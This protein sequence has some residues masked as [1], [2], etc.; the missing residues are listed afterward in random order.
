M[1]QYSINMFKIQVCQN[2]QNMHILH[3]FA[4]SYL[5]DKFENSSIKTDYPISARGHKMTF[6]YFLTT[7][8][9]YGAIISICPVHCICHSHSPNDGIL[10]NNCCNIPFQTKHIS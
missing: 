6:L 8:T 5:R 3:I 2:M 10:K 1:T 4:G 9:L 7:F